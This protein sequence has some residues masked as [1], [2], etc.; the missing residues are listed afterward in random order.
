MFRMNS[1][2]FNSVNRYRYFY[3]IR[4]G[5]TLSKVILKIYH[6]RYGSDG[7]RQA[8]DQI[9]TDNPEIQHPVC[10]RH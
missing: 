10:H 8:L 3:N 1:E 7:Y 6:Y 4:P 2:Y 9:L 5:D